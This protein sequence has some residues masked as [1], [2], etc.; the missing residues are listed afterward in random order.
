VFSIIKTGFNNPDK[1]PTFYLRFFIFR[2]HAFMQVLFFA[3]G[4]K[5]S[6]FPADTGKSDSDLISEVIG[7]TLHLQ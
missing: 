1:S 2:L 4:H 6:L 5:K 7:A 3:N